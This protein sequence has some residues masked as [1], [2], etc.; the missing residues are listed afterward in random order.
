MTSKLSIQSSLGSLILALG[1]LLPGIV[2]AE[3]A[4]LSIEFSEYRLD[5]GLQVLLHR[6]QSLPVAHVELWYHVGSKDEP[7]GRSGFAHLFEHLMF[8]GSEHW[9]AEYFAPLQ[10][11][12]AR[13]NGTTST[14]RTNYYETVPSNALELA[15]WMEADR[16][17][18]LL[19]AL[20]Q[21]KLDNQRDVVRNERRQN[22][23]IRPYA[24]SRK[25]IA[26][27]IWPVSHPYHRMTIGS[28]E[29]LEAATL[30]DVRS[31][32]STWYVPNNATL[33]VSGDFVEEQVRAWIQQYFGPIP[34][35]PQPSPITEASAELPEAVTV[36]LQDDVQ[37]PRLHWAWQS[38]A[39]FAPGDAELDI[40]SS[41]LTAGK[42][43]RLYRKLVYEERVAKDVQA[44]QYSAGLGSS[45]RII[46]TAAPGRSIE[47]VAVAL[48]GELA[49]FLA[50]GPDERELERAKNNWRSSFY[51]RMEKVAGKAGML[52]SYNHH[53][54]NADYVATDLQRY[55]DVSS[56]GVIEWAKRILNPAHRVTVIVQPRA[57]VELGGAQ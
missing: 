35:G 10:P 28:H 24:V 4:P 40:L 9:D 25:A 1:V 36:E 5:N 37:L 19:P 6:D 13:V 23:E 27:A 22:Y 16:M 29:D 15:L 20:T 45:Y 46:A 17:G 38:P 33:V 52:Q 47:E 32:F 8:N 44:V 56:E 51:L 7:A 14:E 2:V 3:T 57:A 48:E 26:E 43:S 55:L 11:L 39:L 34:G 18:F 21:E 42:A 50:E 30:D 31:F 54:G 53:T 49:A 41:L 12:G